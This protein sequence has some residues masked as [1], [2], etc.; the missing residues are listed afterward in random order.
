MW[1]G[2]PGSPVF[3][4]YTLKSWMEPG[5]EVKYMYCVITVSNQTMP[6]YMYILCVYMQI[7][8]MYCALPYFIGA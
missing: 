6:S 7:T 8:Y 3:L 4:A 1:L 2:I 5:D